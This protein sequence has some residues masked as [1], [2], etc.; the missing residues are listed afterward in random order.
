M[1]APKTANINI[2]VGNTDYIINHSNFSSLEVKRT[3]KDVCDSFVLKILDNDACEIE[4]ALLTGNNYVKVVYIDDNLSINKTLAGFIYKMESS[5]INNRNMLSLSGF[6]STSIRDKFEKYSFAWNIVPKFNWKDVLG[7]AYRGI[8]NE[9]YSEDSVLD[10]MW[11]SDMATLG[12]FFKGLGSLFSLNLS[13][14]DNYQEVIDNIFERNLISVDKQGNYYMQKYKDLKDDSAEYNDRMTGEIYSD[15]ADKMISR[16]NGSY[17]IPIKPDKIMKLICCGGN[18]SDLLEAEYTDYKGTNFYKQDISNAEWYF[19]KKWYEKMGKFEGLGYGNFKNNHTLKYDESEFRQEKQSFL[20][21]IYNFV[22]LKSTE[23][24]DNKEYTNFYLS[25]DE[26]SG[27]NKGT[28]TLD[29]LDVSVKPDNIPQYIY[30]GKFKDGGTNKGRMISFNPTLDILTSMITKG[31]YVDSNSGADI[32][33]INLLGRE[34]VT[35]NTVDASTKITSNE[36]RYNVKWGVVKV[37]MATSNTANKDIA[38][39]DIIKAFEEA[40]SKAYRAT[41]TI[42]GFNTLAP[43]DYIDIILLPKNDTGLPTHHH[44]S[45]TYFILSVKNTISDDGTFKTDLDLIKNVGNTGDTA[46]VELTKEEEEE[47]VKYVVKASGSTSTNEIM[48]NSVKIGTGRDIR[49]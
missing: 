1:A 8:Y 33:G 47:E 6:I 36:G 37:S 48:S 18:Y 43:Q 4:A 7:V 31:T 42:L 45:G 27:N 22:L 34:G 12:E 20:E 40:E 11:Q 5:F 32:S 49:L 10:Q 21:F 29:R 39:N 46:M 44:M 2:T 41:A 15:D 35:E 17:I 23:V 25:F 3:A 13:K 9:N 16:S 24:K 26:G 30:Y 38:M 19:I 14:W 28:V